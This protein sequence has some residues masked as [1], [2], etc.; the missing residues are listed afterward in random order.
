MCRRSERSHGALASSNR[1]WKEFRRVQPLQRSAARRSLREAG[2]IVEE[3]SKQEPPA[4]G[5]RVPYPK[6]QK[7]NS[8]DTLDL[9]GSSIGGACRGRAILDSAARER[10]RNSFPASTRRGRT[11]LRQVSASVIKESSSENPLPRPAQEEPVKDS[12]RA[13]SSW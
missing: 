12:R 6:G 9:A 3:L 8:N 10:M 2:E 5:I 1:G 13:P 11:Y 4:H 7:R